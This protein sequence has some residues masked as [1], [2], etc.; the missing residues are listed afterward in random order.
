MAWCVGETY[1]AIAGEDCDPVAVRLFGGPTIRKK[2]RASIVR[3][4]RQLLLVI[5]EPGTDAGGIGSA[6]TMLRAIRK[7][8]HVLAIIDGA[9]FEDARQ[10][11]D[12]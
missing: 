10:A 6:A 8:D 4:S 7:L 12:A 3:T 1:I 11:D 5:P 2:K 9:K